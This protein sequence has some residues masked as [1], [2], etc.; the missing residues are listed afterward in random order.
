MRTFLNLIALANCL[1]KVL[2]VGISQTTFEDSVL[3]TQLLDK[4]DSL[5]MSAN[6]YALVESLCDSAVEML[7]RHEPVDRWLLSRAFYC[8]GANFVALR[9]G[10]E[11][12]SFFEECMQLRLSMFPEDHP[13]IGECWLGMANAFYLFSQHDQSRDAAKKALD[14]FMAAYGVNDVWVARCYNALANCTLF[15]L[16]LALGYL[17]KAIRVLKNTGHENSPDA[18]RSYLLMGNRN[19]AI[20]N[21]AAIESTDKA[22]EISNSIGWSRYPPAGVCWLIQGIAWGNKLYTEKALQCIEKAR[23]I[24]LDNFGELNPLTATAWLKTGETLYSAGD[25]INCQPYYH[26]ALNT[27]LQ[28]NNQNPEILHHLYLDL[29]AGHCYAEEWNPAIDC[30]EKAG[31]AYKKFSGPESFDLLSATKLSSVWFRKGEYQIARQLNSSILEYYSRNPTY[32]FEL[33]LGLVEMD[34]LKND[35]STSMAFLDT[36]ANILLRNDDPAFMEHLAK[37]YF[38]KGR[39]FLLENKLEMASGFFEKALATIPDRQI[40]LV[41]QADIAGNQALCSLEKYRRSKL[42]ADLE[43]AR[44][45]FQ[46]GIEKAGKLTLALEDDSKNYWSNSFF[47]LYGGLIETNLSFFQQA[48]NPQ[49]VEEAFLQSENAKAKVL[50]DAFAR[51]RA[52]K[53]ADVPDSVL[54]A[55][56]HLKADIAVLQQS[57]FNGQKT[58]DSIHIHEWEGRIVDKKQGLQSLQRNIETN[59]PAYHRLRYSTVTSSLAKMQRLVDDRTALLEYFVG[60]SSVFIFSL[61][62]NDLR[63]T[64]LPK[65]AD[66]EASVETLRKSLKDNTLRFT[67]EDAPLFVAAAGKLYRWLLREPLAAL[68]PQVGNLVIVPDG[69]LGYV[70]FEVLGDTQDPTDF[71]TFPYLL[72]RFNISYAASASLLLE[73]S[74]RPNWSGV[75]KL[76][77]GFAPSYSGTDTLDFFAATRRELVRGEKYSLPGAAQEVQEIAALLSGESFLGMDATE[78]NF[79][80]NAYQYRILHLAMHSVLEDRNPLFSK[81]LF[82]K[83]EIP[84]QASSFED[85]DLNAAELYSIRLPAELVVLSACNTGVGKLHRGEGIMSLS[86][87]FTYAGVPATVMSLWKAP[88]EATRKIM[89]SFYGNLKI[90]MRKDEALREAK[91]SYLANCGDTVASPYYWAGFVAGGEM[92][93]LFSKN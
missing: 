23:G 1:M 25:L 22:L 62:K 92:G 91:L 19:L 86:R 5:S 50:R 14:I 16:P 9:K 65:P 4:A 21:D 88:D 15:D 70:P 37:V 74:D 46:E 89:V 52:L 67:G 6:E 59:F 66:F 34:K 61:T 81:L 7:K 33:P 82:T 26:K 51:Q 13:R 44:E 39:V 12:K 73:Q 63:L 83:S 90:G 35:F 28:L 42:V 75:T 27:M 30:F 53:V 8:K 77:A 80:E 11:A 57:V 93:P 58:P 49:Y 55:E 60:D 17:E 78:Q 68:S 48:Q 45:F 10:G 32:A 43:A 24:F 47:Y 72:R 84:R 56:S 64:A 29:G 40:N 36:C 38:Q 79:K 20:N 87:A 3:V 2:P 31:E 18:I 41:L 69:M 85:G 54:E 71:R 76:F